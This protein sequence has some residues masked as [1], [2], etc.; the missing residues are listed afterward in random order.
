MRFGRPALVAVAFGISSSSDAFLSPSPMLLHPPT[1]RMGGGVGGGGGSGGG[2]GG[3]VVHAARDL[4]ARNLR[5][6]KAFAFTDTLRWEMRSTLTSDEEASTTGYDDDGGGDG[7]GGG[8]AG[9]PSPPEDV[10]EYP[11]MLST[12]VYEIVNADQHK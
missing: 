12:G 10:P 2:A 8:S 4:I 11:E 6:V 1:A 3:E 7:A 5:L 9:G